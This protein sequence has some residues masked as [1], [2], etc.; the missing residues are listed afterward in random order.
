MGLEGVA[1]KTDNLDVALLPLGCKLGNTAQ[2]GGADGGCNHDKIFGL[3][4][5]RLGQIRVCELTEVL[6]VREKDSPATLLPLV[7]L[8]VALGGLGREVG[9]N[10]TETER[11]GC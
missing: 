8:N 6:G 9:G 1:R 4:I 11:H 3:K 2:L 10:V 7:E 5:F